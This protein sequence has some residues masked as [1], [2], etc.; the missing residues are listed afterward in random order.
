VSAPARPTEG[1]ER[2]IGLRDALEIANR[3]QRELRFD[4]A[5]SVYLQVLEQVPGEPN[6][7][8]FL[9]VLRHQQGRNDEALALMERALER[10]P[11]EPGLWLNLAN[12]LIECG[13]HDDAVKALDNVVAL[14][15]DWVLAHN[16]LGILHARRQDWPQA[17]AAL[18]AGIA[19]TPDAA[20]LHQNLAGVYLQTGRLAQ[21]LHHSL[22]SHGLDRNNV[23][24]R[25]FIS[26]SLLQMGRRD[27]ALANLHEWLAEEPDN[28][29]ALHYLAAAGGAEMPARASDAYVQR[30]FD[31]FADSFE[32]H[33]QKLDYAAPAH[34]VE[35]LARQRHHLP[36]APVVLD[37]GCGT[38]L[39]GP[40]LRPIAT[41]LE[42]VDLSDGML[43]RARARGDY[44]A[45]HQAELTAFLAVHPR[46]FD[47]IVSADVLNYF[48]ALGEVFAAMRR[49]LRP[50][51]M[52]V[53]TVEALAD[54][55]RDVTL[56]VHGRYSHSSRHVQEVLAAQGWQLLAIERL[57]LRT[58][59]K[60]PVVGWGFSALAPS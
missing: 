44:D 54:E 56:A 19:L 8:H 9:G 38:G 45:L 46:A 4:E 60:Q 18:K 57:V 51:G 12:V 48:G 14:R 41:R 31:R 7:L 32:R 5:E 15:P 24:A 21:C 23:A 55:S 3:L 16:N 36:D 37:A 10:M 28:A 43:Q 49:A 58:E 59:E 33:L 34:M 47:A 30:V 17:E 52:V 1:A 22:Q 20:Y 25:V 50:G 26:R 27:E 13:F 40:L 42:G 35:M 29:E 53:F 2:D 6:T 39:C 11:Q